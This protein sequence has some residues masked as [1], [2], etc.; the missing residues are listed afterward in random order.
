MLTAIGTLGCS[1]FLQVL[2]W[3]M[4]SQ[5]PRASGWFSAGSEPLR[6]AGEWR[7]G[8]RNSKWLL[9]SQS[10]LRPLKLRALSVSWPSSGT[11]PTCSRRLGCATE[12]FLREARVTKADAETY[13]RTFFAKK[14]LPHEPFGRIGASTQGIVW[15]APENEA[16]RVVPKPKAS[17]KLGHGVEARSRGLPVAVQEAFGALAEDVMALRSQEKSMDHTI[18]LYR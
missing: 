10:F 11:S 16:V 4:I 9:E 7:S 1:F 13:A 14:C 18:I 8:L 2:C 12:L 3:S 5:T 6:A 15:R 17:A